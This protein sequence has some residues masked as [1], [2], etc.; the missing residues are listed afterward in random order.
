MKFNND[1]AMTSVP[2]TFA[3]NESIRN[4]LCYQFF[5]H[6]SR[7]FVEY[8]NIQLEFYPKNPETSSPTPF[9]AVADEN[10]NLRI[11]WF[12]TA[13]LQLFSESFKFFQDSS[14]DL[15]QFSAFDLFIMTLGKLMTTPN[16]QTNLK[17]H[18][19]YML[20]ILEQSPSVLNVNQSL[21]GLL[22]SSTDQRLN[23]SSMLWFYYKKLV[24]LKKQNSTSPDLGDHVEQVCL[25]SAKNHFANY[26]CWNTIRW[27]FDNE[28]NDNKK[29]AIFSQVFQFCR[30]NFTDCSAWD[31]LAYFSKQSSLKQYSSYNVI[32]HR[33]IQ[34]LLKL[35][36]GAQGASD[37][38]LYWKDQNIVIA[39][40]QEVM[41]MIRT[42]ERASIPVFNYLLSVVTLIPPTIFTAELSLLKASLRADVS[43]DQKDKKGHEN[44]VTLQQA[45][46]VE[47]L[48]EFLEK[49]E[50]DKTLLHLKN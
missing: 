43:Q 29:S 37:Q 31:T 45:E 47:Q 44:L 33:R 41:H 23:K 8:T 20:E 2:E 22:L 24:V 36:V 5:E 38:R 11:V 49:L 40:A 14:T 9:I 25:K 21:V 3:L 7:Y 35:H 17:R 42:L 34:R 26:Y 28:L 12:Q 46:Y 13:R 16:D 10:D 27:I 48:M 32:S 6:Y 1:S 30:S 18:E 39:T 50:K 4:T 19:K 15:Q